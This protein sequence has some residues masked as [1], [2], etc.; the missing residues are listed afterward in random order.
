MEE[1]NYFVTYLPKINQTANCCHQKYPYL[2]QET[3]SFPPFPRFT[4]L[5]HKFS[6]VI[7]H[8]A[9]GD[10]AFSLFF[11]SGHQGAAGNALI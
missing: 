11:G 1:E 3:P 5:L 2:V 9:L 6:M 4:I 7:G 10:S 8:S